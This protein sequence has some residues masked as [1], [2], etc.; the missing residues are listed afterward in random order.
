ML[1]QTQEDYL[2][3]IYLLKAELNRPIKSVELAAKMKLTKSTISQ[4][5]KELQ[6]KEWITQEKYRPIELT[7]MG[8]QLAENLTYKHRIIEMFLLEKLGLSAKEVH[9]EAHLLEHA[10]SEKVIL[11]IAELLENPKS[12]PHGQ[13]LPPFNKGL[14]Q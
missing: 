10:C 1:T 11:K 6:T 2:R 9:Q 14:E 13:P 3:A 12:C 4:R 5:L 7:E 8:R